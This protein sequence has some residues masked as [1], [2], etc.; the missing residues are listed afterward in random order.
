[1]FLIKLG[2]YA[3]LSHYAIAFRLLHFHANESSSGNPH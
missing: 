3:V 1:M 2:H